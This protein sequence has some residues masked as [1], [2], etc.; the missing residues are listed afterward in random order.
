MLAEYVVKLIFWPE[1]ARQA[2]MI[3]NILFG[4]GDVMETIAWL[5]GED[6][7][8]LSKETNMAASDKPQATNDKLK[9]IEQEKTWSLKLE[10]YGLID[11]LVESGLASSNG[12]AKKLIQWGGIYLNEKKIEDI[13]HFVSSSDVINGVILLRKGKKGYRVV[14]VG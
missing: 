10:A 3:T 13:A 7:D 5:S 1:A 14:R 8:A 6:I 11:L 9:T 4:R 2:Q 12:E